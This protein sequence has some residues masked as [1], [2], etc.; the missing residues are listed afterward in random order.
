[1]ISQSVRWSFSDLQYHSFLFTSVDI[2]FFCQEM[3]IAWPQSRPPT[4]W[5]SQKHLNLVAANPY[6]KINFFSSGPL[7]RP[8]LPLS[9]LPIP[10][11]LNILS[12][13]RLLSSPDST[14]LHF[15]V[16]AVVLRA[17]AA[18]SALGGGGG[19]GG[20]GVKR[21]GRWWRPQQCWVLRRWWKQQWRQPLEGQIHRHGLERGTSS[22]GEGDNE[23][24][25]GRSTRGWQQ[26]WE[27]GRDDS[28]PNGSGAVN[29]SVRRGLSTA[30][31]LGKTAPPLEIF[32]ATMTPVASGVT[33]VAVAASSDDNGGSRRDAWKTPLGPRVYDY[34]FCLKIFFSRAA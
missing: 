26:L 30:L 17:E 7:N 10:S 1:M 4:N 3:K 23:G 13:C 8:C 12:P 33:M 21:S 27:F 5:S 29:A 31:G 18:V 25:F 32:G 24:E 16:R 34:L 22:R 2:I 9:C 11:L 15:M 19:E 14:F 28:G 20:G 6:A